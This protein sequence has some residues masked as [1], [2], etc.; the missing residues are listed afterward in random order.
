M[1]V[2]F[3]GEPPPDSPP[4]VVGDWCTYDSGGPPLLVVDTTTWWVTVAYRRPRGKI[5]EVKLFR[6]RLRRSKMGVGRCPICES[7]TDRY[8]F[9]PACKWARYVR[10]QA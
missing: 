7:L 2:V 3:R 5:E 1:S 6:P 4:L 9:C 8:P 10:P